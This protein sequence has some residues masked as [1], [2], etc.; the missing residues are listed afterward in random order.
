M[1]RQR[2]KHPEQI[3]RY[4]GNTLCLFD[5]IDLHFVQHIGTRCHLIGHDDV[6]LCF[7]LDSILKLSIKLMPTVLIVDDSD[8]VRIAVRA[9]FE[10][11]PGFS[12]VGEAVNGM[13]AINK[14]DE[15][16]PDL[17]VLD[18]SMPIMNGLEAAETL[19]L[20]SPSTPIFILTAHG[21]PEVD[22]AA[23]AAGVDAVF[24]KGGD[25]MDKMIARARTTFGKKKLNKSTVK[26]K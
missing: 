22:R 5:I 13:D 8:S 18:L 12:V 23:R 6:L 25:D 19:K 14:A 9:L 7:S 3:P 11:E 26:Q 17:I 1:C 2:S 21:G 16:A 20:N 4:A 15:L 24:S 10:A